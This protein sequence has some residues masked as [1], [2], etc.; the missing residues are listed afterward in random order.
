MRSTQIVH[1]STIECISF[2]G[3]TRL[4]HFKSTRAFR[5]A[6]ATR[7]REIDEEKGR[8][9]RRGK[10]DRR[11]FNVSLTRRRKT[12]QCARPRVR[13]KEPRIRQGATTKIPGREAGRGFAGRIRMREGSEEK[14]DAVRTATHEQTENRGN[15][16]DE[17]Q[18]AARN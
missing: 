16:W 9:R 15:A 13:I 12:E 3:A 14:K 10:E 17:R 11:A 4:Q 6:C 5:R 8:R 2:Q 18:A 1:K 7:E